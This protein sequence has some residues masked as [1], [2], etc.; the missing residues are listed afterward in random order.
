MATRRFRPTPW[1]T[2][3]AV[4]G[5][6]ATV[7]L[8]MWQTDRAEQKLASAAAQER[9][10]AEAAIVLGDAALDPD[11]SEHRRVQARGRFEPRGMI[12][13]D[14]RIRQGI[15]GYEVVMPLMLAGGRMYVLVNRGWIAGQ[16]DR[17]ELPQVRTPA[18]EVT[19][20]G[21]AAVPGRRVYELSANT[22]EGSVWQNLTVERY[23]ERMKYP[24][25]GIVI[26]QTN[27]LGDG[28]LRAW[29]APDRGVN[30]HR[31][32]AVQWFALAVLIAVVYVVLSF[33]RVHA[34]D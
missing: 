14:N 17:R 21:R 15:A 20:L 6:A 19:V 18:E 22:A 29:P 12:L 31:S 24:I 2:L 32:Y 16:R 25:H 9:L 5:V 33:P 23:R 34:N 1:G 28:L 7:S 3:A 4:A 10:A 26:E 8:G 27:D 30:T 11:R 13:L